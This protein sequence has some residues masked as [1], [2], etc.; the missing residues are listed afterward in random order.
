M[1][2]RALSIA[3]FILFLFGASGTSAGEAAL[4]PELSRFADLIVERLE[5]MKGVAAYKFRARR[6]VE[7]L[8]REAAVIEAGMEQAGRL[9][10]EP[11]SVAPFLQAQMDAAKRVQRLWISAWQS[12]AAPA[13]EEERDLASD[14]RPAISNATYLVLRLLVRARPQLERAE[15]RD[16]L[17]DD[18]R[19]G[20]LGLGLGE[21][22]AWAIIDG[23]VKARLSRE[24]GPSRVEK[25]RAAGVLRVGTTGDYPPFSHWN[26][27]AFIGIDIDLARLLTADLGVEARFVRTSWPTLM[28]DL[29]ADKF[30]I[31][32]S[33]ITDTAERAKVASF[34]Q[35]YHIG[36][37]API[38]RCDEIE[39]YDDLDE[40]DRDGVRVIVNPGGTN[41]HFTRANINR[42]QIIVFDDNTAIFDE[43]AEGR[44]DVM[45]TDAIEVAFQ[46]ARDPDLCPATPGR[47]FTTSTKALMMPQDEMLRTY[48]DGWLQRMTAMGRLE[49]IFE[50]NLKPSTQPPH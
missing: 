47:T 9:G 45:I 23:A 27:E 41:E 16:A 36:G 19:D 49:A 40:I 18:L 31:A 42:A 39:R 44:A 34:S 14:L 26:G 28:R 10:I 17:A 37:K 50:E 13:P 48:I 5:L 30:D 46:A 4:S 3:T 21:T 35:A 24:S 29:A 12:N 15:N 8:A 6:P 7:D 20:M 2:R 22:D 11:E 25:I 33:G 32:I 43:I 38:A 1:Q